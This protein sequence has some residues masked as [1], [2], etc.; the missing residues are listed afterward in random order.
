M[1]PFHWPFVKFPLNFQLDLCP[2]CFLSVLFILYPFREE[3][4]N[5]IC[6]VTKCIIVLKNDTKLI[7]CQ[8][9]KKI[10]QDFSV[11]IYIDCY[12][13]WSFKWHATPY[14]KWFEKFIFFRPY[15]FFYVSFEQHQKSQYHCLGQCRFSIHYF[16]PTIYM[17][18]LFLFRQL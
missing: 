4:F 11:H 17:L 1:E 8:W 18:K 15:F 6:F 5:S 9:N 14:H 7:Y 12:L 3:S 16:H 13:P 10:I 2:D